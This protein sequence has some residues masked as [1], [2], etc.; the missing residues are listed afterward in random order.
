M[1]KKINVKPSS[2][3]KSLLNLA[4][5]VSNLYYEILKYTA[6]VRYL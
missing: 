3:T 1:D 4:R 5:A 2:I 6:D